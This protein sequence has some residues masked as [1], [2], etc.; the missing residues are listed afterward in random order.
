ERFSPRKSP[1]RALER[2]RY[3]LSQMLVKGFV[4]QSIHDR[5]RDTPLRLAPAVDTESELCPEAVD[6]AKRALEAA[7]GATAARGGYEVTTTIS[8]ALQ[9]LARTAVRENLDAY[10]TR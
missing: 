4:T 9:A 1:E 5:A 3:V 6:E 2:R 7:A 8:P 10:A